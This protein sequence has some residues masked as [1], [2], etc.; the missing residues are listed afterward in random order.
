MSD[1]QPWELTD[2]QIDAAVAQGAAQYK[3]ERDTAIAWGDEEYHERRAIAT[4]AQKRIV[5]W[6]KT[7]SYDAVGGIRVIDMYVWLALKAA[8]GE[9]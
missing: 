7:N 2:E 4:A 6:L 9:G 1:R 5:E 8:G 3:H